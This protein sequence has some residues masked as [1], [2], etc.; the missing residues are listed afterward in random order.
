[1]G[2]G[3]SDAADHD[4]DQSP[5][6]E[7]IPAGRPLVANFG[8]GANAQ[9]S[10]PRQVEPYAAVLAQHA[11]SLQP[12]D[13]LEVYDRLGAD[14]FSNGVHEAPRRAHGSTS[15]PSADPMLKFRGARHVDIKPF[16]PECQ[17]D[18]AKTSVGGAEELSAPLRPTRA[19]I[20]SENSQ[21][22]ASVGTARALQDTLVKKVRSMREALMRGD[23]ANG[24]FQDGEDGFAGSAQGLQSYRAQAVALEAELDRYRDKIRAHTSVSER[25]RREMNILQLDQ[26]IQGQRSSAARK[27]CVE[28]RERLQKGRQECAELHRKAKTEQLR[29]VMLRDAFEQEQTRVGVSLGRAESFVSDLVAATEGTRRVEVEEQSLARECASALSEIHAAEVQDELA[30]ES[31][32][33]RLKRDLLAA[34]AS[35]ARGAE[36][37]VTGFDAASSSLMYATIQS[38][39]N[40]AA[41]QLSEARRRCDGAVVIAHR[42]LANEAALRRS[43]EVLRDELSTFARELRGTRQEVSPTT[44]LEE[45]AEVT[46]RQADVKI[47]GLVAL[48]QQ[49][50]SD[51]RQHSPGVDCARE[52][53]SKF[54]HELD[55]VKSQL[56]EPQ[57]VRPRGSAGFQDPDWR[58]DLEAAGLQR[59]LGKVLATERDMY[60]QVLE[61]QKLCVKQPSSKLQ[62]QVQVLKNEL[63]VK[64]AEIS[65]LAKSSHG[66]VSDGVAKISG[67][68]RQ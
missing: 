52:C 27:E 56:S 22:C 48:W 66:V 33:R 9:A 53:A 61:A 18:S 50:Q 37:E 3:S 12:E 4:I 7:E 54:I 36:S 67:L 32:V 5:T 29:V 44:E 64:D 6:T 23:S 62:Q 11:A 25:Q 13:I 15:T 14:G 1:M 35:I 16:R 19:G 8:H 31:E 28:A 63:Q 20:E 68:L 24:A 45:A 43:V 51:R 10:R 39:C 34:E 57:E 49:S 26:R 40:A 46:I 2:V 65:R 59:R 30:V 58:L 47:A 41:S 60:C 38:E 55:N 42:C 21:Q 17:R